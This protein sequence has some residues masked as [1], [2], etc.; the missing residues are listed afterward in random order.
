MIDNST[1]KN[2]ELIGNKA[3]QDFKDKFRNDEINPYEENN[4]ANLG[5]GEEEEPEPLTA[6]Y[7][8]NEQIKELQTTADKRVNSIIQSHLDPIEKMAEA[9][10]KQTEP[11]E[12]NYQNLIYSVDEVNRLYNAVNLKMDKVLK[13]ADPDILKALYEEQKAEI[14]V[15]IENLIKTTIEKEF[16]AKQAQFDEEYNKRNLELD[17]KKLELDKELEEIN[18]RAAEVADME[19]NVMNILEL[20]KQEKEEIETK[21]QENTLLEQK[22]NEEN[23]QIIS[24]LTDENRELKRKCDL[25]IEAAKEQIEANKEQIEANK[26]ALALLEEQKNINVKQSEENDRLLLEKDKEIEKIIE[27]GKKEYEKN[28]KESQALRAEIREE[29]EEILNKSNHVISAFCV[30]LI[31]VGIILIFTPALGKFNNNEWFVWIINVAGGGCLFGGVWPA[32]RWFLKEFGWL[33]G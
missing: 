28:W 29:K 16:T 17:N 26:E 19:N 33:K 6:D 7:L 9:I 14:T 8:T 11:I 5:F 15:F 4:D 12:D 27:N 10:K 31:V 25:Q 30:V 20:M 22:I 21:I 32:I 18:A 23:K 13:T 3:Y 2:A 24:Q 1:L